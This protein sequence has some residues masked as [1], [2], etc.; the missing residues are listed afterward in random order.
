MAQLIKTTGETTEI[1]PVNG[2]DL[3]LDELQKYVDGYIEI[4]DLGNDEIFVINDEGKFTCEKN[5]EA[6]KIA[7]QRGAIYILDYIAGDVV[8]CKNKEVQ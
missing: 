5:E 8:L 6:T 7:Q 2:T 3:Q 4:V 1:H